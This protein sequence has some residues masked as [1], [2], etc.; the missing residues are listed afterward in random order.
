MRHATDYRQ[1]PEIR[2][3]IKINVHAD[4]ALMTDYS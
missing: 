4:T 3:D 1:L 2:I